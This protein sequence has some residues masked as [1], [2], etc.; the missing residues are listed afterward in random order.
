MGSQNRII[1][2]GFIYKEIFAMMWI[3]VTIRPRVSHNLMSKL[4]R[5][6][7][8]REEARERVTLLP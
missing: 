8:V 4:L 1:S 2:R 3:M 6:V 7:G 5:G